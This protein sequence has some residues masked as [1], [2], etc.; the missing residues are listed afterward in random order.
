MKI[1]RSIMN[2]IVVFVLGL[3]RLDRNVR[4]LRFSKGEICEN[5]IYR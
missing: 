4:P 1:I 5:S 3:E 2:L